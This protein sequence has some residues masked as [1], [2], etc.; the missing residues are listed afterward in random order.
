MCDSL[1]PL[2]A[3][4]PCWLSE[5]KKKSQKHEYVNGNRNGGRNG[6]MSDNIE[7][8][9]KPLLSALESIELQINLEPQMTVLKE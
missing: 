1:S 2:I 9:L 7:C 4:S 6:D 3:A 5:G 8:Q